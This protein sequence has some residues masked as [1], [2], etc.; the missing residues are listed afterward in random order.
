MTRPDQKKQQAPEGSEAILN[1]TTFKNNKDG[2]GSK[3]V[4]PLSKF[5]CI[6]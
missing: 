5:T 1:Y 2:R 6:Y 4:T 3:C